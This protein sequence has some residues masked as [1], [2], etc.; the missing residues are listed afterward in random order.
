MTLLT[1]D[2]VLWLH[3]TML[4]ATGGAEGLRDKGS[5]ESSLYHAF[6]SF[7]GQDLYPS[8]EEKAARKAYSI[9]H[10]HPFVDGN[11]RTGLFVMLIFLEINGIVLKFT[12]EELVDLGNGLASGNMDDKEVLK[13]IRSHKDE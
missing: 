5:L 9:I 11:K 2:Q 6:A 8:L 12:Q 3:A 13:W 10:S 1:I 4:Q 7:E